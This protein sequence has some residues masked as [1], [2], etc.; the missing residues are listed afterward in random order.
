MCFF[1]FFC[2]SHEL[3]PFSALFKSHYFDGYDLVFAKRRST[4]TEVLRRKA[5]AIASAVSSSPFLFLLPLPPPLPPSPT[6]SPSLSP[7]TLGV[8]PSFGRNL[9]RDLPQIALSLFLRT[10]IGGSFI[11]NWVQIFAKIYIVLEFTPSKEESKDNY[12]CMI[13]ILIFLS[14]ND[15]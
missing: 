14:P 6:P 1:F 12:G 4:G 5:S 13:F 3:P 10:F 15:T 2:L 9:L 7:S 8:R 11:G